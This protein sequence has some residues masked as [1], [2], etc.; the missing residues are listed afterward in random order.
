MSLEQEQYQ[1]LNVHAFVGPEAWLSWLAEHHSQQE[2]IWIKFARKG[3]G[4]ESVNYEQGRD[5]ALRYGWIDGQAK[6]LDATHYLQ[7][8]SPRRARS[9]WSQINCGIVET[10]IA[11]G[12]MFPSGLRE[13]EAAKADGR[14]AAAYAPPSTIEV[15]A[16]FQ[17]LLDEHPKA[18]EAFSTLKSMERYRILYQL[19]DA[20]KP[21]TREK[22]RRQFLGELLAKADNATP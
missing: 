2:A 5:A 6:S 8:F 9:K 11:R 1:G 3:S 19:H 4:L 13:V 21:E 12:L 10:M 14:W 17:A 18:A 16:E 7:K 15:P 22:R 20:K